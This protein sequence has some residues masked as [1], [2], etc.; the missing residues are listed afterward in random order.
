MLTYN[1]I[2]RVAFLFIINIGDALFAF[3][4]G[5]IA[6]IQLQISENN[7][8]HLFINKMKG[9]EEFL[10]Q[11]CAGE[12]QRKRVEAFFAY[13]FFTKNKLHLIESKHLKGLLP[14][15]L[16]KDLLYYAARDILSPMFHHFQSDNLIR[17]VA[18]V[19]SN[20]TFMPGDYIIYKD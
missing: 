7:E 14:Y 5:L 1:D 20:A 15:S 17:E 6:S 16:Q 9:I 19:L 8:Y 11:V 12:S 18:Y 10:T 2:E 4:F 13:S 3:A